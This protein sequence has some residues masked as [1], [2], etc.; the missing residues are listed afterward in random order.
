MPRIL[1][2]PQSTGRQKTPVKSTPI[3][4]PTLPVPRLPRS[5]YPLYRLDVVPTYIQHNLWFALP[6]ATDFLRQRAILTYSIRR[7]YNYL[8]CWSLRNIA[9]VGAPT[10]WEP[11]DL[12]SIAEWTQGERESRI[13][14]P[15][16]GS[17][18]TYN[19]FPSS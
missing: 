15:K 6:R 17:W 18:T 5:A 7:F 16:S 3:H 11:T 8:R 10:V 12:I 2:Q 9:T 4:G 14:A 13:I 1:S 19:N